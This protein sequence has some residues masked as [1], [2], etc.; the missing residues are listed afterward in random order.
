MYP[1]YE[2]VFGSYKLYILNISIVSDIAL[3]FFDY[4][5]FVIIYL[6]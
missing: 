6:F 1:K 3:N 5:L 4:F 2:I